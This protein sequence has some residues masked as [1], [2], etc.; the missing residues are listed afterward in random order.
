MIVSFFGAY[1]ISITVGP[2]LAEMWLFRQDADDS[3]YIIHLKTVLKILFNVAFIYVLIRIIVVS[4]HFYNK[5]T[6]K[7]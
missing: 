2:F 5:V 4:I 1:I 3:A 7:K 6:R